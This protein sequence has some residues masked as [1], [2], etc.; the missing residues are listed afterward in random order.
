[1]SPE[2]RILLD[3][4]LSAKSVTLRFCV[5]AVVSC[6]YLYLAFQ[7][8]ESLFNIGFLV[9]FT[10]LLL[11]S[12]VYRIINFLTIYKTII[13]KG[14]YRKEKKGGCIELLYNILLFISPFFLFIFINSVLALGILFGVISAVGILDSLFYLY[15]KNREAH[16]GGH[17]KAFIEKGNKPG[18][19][20]WGLS[21]HSEDE[22]DRS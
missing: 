15:V 17:F 1:M 21:L 22:I 20:V 2:G 10:F 12:L 3:Y 4:P 8:N 9:S 13:L 6:L 5:S 11:F 7:T 18:C 19:Y 16:L 14:E